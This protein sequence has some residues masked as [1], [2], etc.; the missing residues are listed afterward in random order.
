MGNIRVER[1]NPTAYDNG[2]SY[3]VYKETVNKYLK[4]DP[5]ELNFQNRVILCMLEKLLINTDIEI[6][7]TST[8]YDRGKRNSK[9]LNTTQ[10]KKTGYAPPD[11]L[12]A[13]NWNIDNVNN[14]VD[15]LAAIEIKSPNSKEAI[16]GKQ[17]EKYTEH[18]KKETRA[19]LSANQKVI[20]TDCY[21]WQFFEKKE[22]FV[23]TT[24][25]DLVDKNKQW[26]EDIIISNNIDNSLLEA[27]P[28]EWKQLQNRILSFLGIQGNCNV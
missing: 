23:D 22:G 3:T 9:T 18:V 25:I 5:R 10:F 24:P 8:L 27:E 20:L 14:K 17:F 26:K 16:C 11:L 6:V 1:K 21:R 15:Y 4:T 12:L 2:F 7:D 13:R 28:K 19:H